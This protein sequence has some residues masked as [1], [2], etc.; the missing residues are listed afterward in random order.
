MFCGIS[1]CLCGTWWKRD[2]N[3]TLIFK[4]WIKWNKI[5]KYLLSFV[6]N[7]SFY[8][9]KMDL[10]SKVWCTCCDAMFGVKCCCLCG[11]WWK[12]DANLVLDTMKQNNINAFFPSTLTL[13]SSLQDLINCN[14]DMVFKVTNNLSGLKHTPLFV[15]LKGQKSLKADKHLYSEGL[16]RVCHWEK[17]CD[18]S[19]II[20]LW[21]NF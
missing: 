18:N 14:Y 12:R 2:E 4:Y 11:T 15:S 8:L 1:C 9:F 5:T 20:Y 16:T 13:F 19:L 21:M 17:S 3:Y 7:T 6:I 10:K